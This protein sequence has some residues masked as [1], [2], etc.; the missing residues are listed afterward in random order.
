MRSAG[1]GL[2]MA[3]GEGTRRPLAFV[4][5]TAVDPAHLPEYTRRFAAILDRHQLRAG[6]YG[7]AS[8]GCLH[9][10]PFMDLT[11]PAE[12]ATMRAVAEEIRDLVAEFGGANS[13]EHGDGLARSEFNRVIFGDELYE[14][15]REVKRLFD[16]H[17]LL[18]PG[19]IVDAPAM[20]DNLRDAALPAAP[21]LRT[22][23]V[24]CSHRRDARGRR[25]LHEHRRLSQGID[26][27]DVPLVHG[28]ARGGAQH[29]RSRQRAGA[30]PVAARSRARRWATSASTRSSTSVSNARPARANVP[31]ASTW[32]R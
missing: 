8:V 5:D 32:P 2:L 20:T 15:M 16:P 3:A 24:I 26:G 14:A 23:I 19:K 21:R 30:R 25:P 10:R 6:F 18:N 11:R 28:H 22:D 31:S 9:I 29:A 1:L 7:H 12:V 13:S 27:G 4:E 17:G